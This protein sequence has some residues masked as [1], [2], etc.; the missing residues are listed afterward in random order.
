MTELGEGPVAQETPQGTFARKATGLVREVSPFS[1]FVFNMAGQPTSIFLAVSIFFTLGLYPGGSIWLGFAMALVAALII[2]VCYGLFTSAM[3]RS[4]GDYVLVGRVTHPAIG[5]ISSFFWTSGVI[6]SIAFVAL[7]FVTVA[8]GP[9]LTA[10]GLVSGD[11]S[12]VTAGEDLATSKGWQM[13]IGSAVI[14]LSAVLLGGGWR[15]T[16]RIMNALWVVTMLGLAT[17]FLVLLFKSQ[18]GF[19]NSFNQFAG[20]I[21]GERDTYDSVISNAAKEGVDT[22]PAFSLDNFWPTWAAICSLSLYSFLSIYISGEVRRAKDTT[23]V[24]V[25]SLA[26]VVHIGIAALLAAVFFWKF[27]HDFFV[28]IN[29]LGEETYPFAAPPYYTFLTSIAGGSTL[30]AWWLFIS[31]AVA[32]PLLILPNI[33][34]AVRTFFAWALDGILPSR[35]ARVSPRTHAPNYAIGLTVILSILV[36]WWAV[37]NE[38]G[39]FSV[40]IEAVLL[41]LVTMILLGISAVLLPYRR[42]DAWRSSA[43]TQRF[44]GVPIVALAGGLVAIVLAGLLAVYMRYPDLG[45]D[46]GQFFRDSAIILGASLLTFFV[47]RAARRRQGVDVDKLAAEIPPE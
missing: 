35:F 18:D 40:L 45:I 31:F 33:T 37:S 29:S 16:T 8:L 7:A 23:Q 28:A 39:F 43:T 1:T 21:T 20:S 3:P 36:L 42:P 41:Q 13:G 5:L 12:L 30:L 4:G 6:L 14:L 15:W 25:M 19:V 11:G 32:Y 26:T 27:G 10:V 17:V 9:S 38:E 2:C 44:L 46:R 34:I 47:A 22:S 24:K